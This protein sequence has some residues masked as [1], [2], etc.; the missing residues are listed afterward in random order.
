[1]FVGRTRELQ[2]LETAYSSDKSELAVIYGRSG[3]GRSALVAQFLRNKYQFFSFEAPETVG[4]STQ[5]SHFTRRLARHTGDPSLEGTGF[6]DWYQAFDYA[7]KKV[8]LQQKDGKKYILFLDELQWMAVGKNALIGLLAHFWDTYWK[9]HPTMLILCGSVSSFMINNVLRSKTFYGRTTLEIN[10]KGLQPAEAYTILGKRRS[11]EEAMKY[12]L[13]FGSVPKYLEQVDMHQSF[14][15][16]MNRMCF[17]KNGGMLQE[18][19]TIFHRQFRKPDTYI[20][21]ITLLANNR[22]TSQ[23]ISKTSGIRSGGG[24]SSYIDS[25]INADMIIP[26]IPFDKE[27]GTKLVKYETGDE[28]LHFYLKYMKPNMHII[29]QSESSNLFETVTRRGFHTWLGLAFERF[30]HK[31]IGYLAKIMCF[32]DEVMRAGPLFGKTDER[33]RIDLVYK[34][35]DKVAVVC[36]IKYSINEIATTVIPEVQRK[37]SLLNP[38]RG[39]TIRKALISLYGPDKALADSRFFDH[40]I[41]LRNIFEE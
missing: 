1:M 19:E 12:L 17:S 16:N 21:I 5:L 30:C 15:E 10:L 36:E 35:T 41:T 27:Q 11:F 3:I 7:T 2:L 4:T 14:N 6:Q 13:V 22:C 37:C 28:F 34:R 20:K 24:L 9:Q 32:S 26:H 25:L 38:P 40:S 8:F 23:K 33:F 18:A 29:R 31:H 39:F